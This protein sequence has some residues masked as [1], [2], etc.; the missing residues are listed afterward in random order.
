MRPSRNPSLI[1][2]VWCRCSI[3]R[4]DSSVFHEP[5]YAEPHVRW[6]GRATGVTRSP[7]R[8]HRSGD[9]PPGKMN[10]KNPMDELERIV[11]AALADFASCRDPAALENSKAK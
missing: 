6:C 4:A 10:A 11:A 1:V 5:P 9:A 8:S 2:G 3:R 7:T